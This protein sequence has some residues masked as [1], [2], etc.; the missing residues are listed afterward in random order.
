VR[1]KSTLMQ[2]AQRSYRVI[3]QNLPEWAALDV[4]MNGVPENSPDY[5]AYYGHKGRR[6]ERRVQVNA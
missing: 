1:Y 4:V 3:R 6:N 2:A 5:F